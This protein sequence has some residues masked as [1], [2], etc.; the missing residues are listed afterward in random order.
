VLTT[1]KIDVRV[2]ASAKNGFDTW[3][4]EFSPGSDPGDNDWQP[5]FSASDQVPE[6]SNVVSWNLKDAG[7]G[8]FTLRLRME[9]KDG[10]YAQKVIHIEINYTPPTA[11]PAPATP[12]ATLEPP[13]PT[14]TLVAP[15]L[16]PV[17]ETAQPLL[18]G[19]P[20]ITP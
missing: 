17:T 6:P 7:N 18:T 10:G 8:N 14:F 12:T 13:T 2:I 20:T 19:T 3:R 11:T 5:L 1:E 16:I 9:N 15:T 4:L